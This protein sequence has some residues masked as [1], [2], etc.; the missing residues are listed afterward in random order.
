M[1]YVE[2]NENDKVEFSGR[3]PR[4]EFDFFKT[5]F[6]QYGATNWFINDCLKKFN[7][8]VRANP[9]LANLIDE[10]IDDLLKHNRNEPTSAA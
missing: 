4:K 9:G 7:D 6:P 10:M 8:K 1:A 2:E 3:V 5:T